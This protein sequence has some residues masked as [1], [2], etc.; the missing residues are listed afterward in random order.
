MKYL[1]TFENFENKEVNE[2]LFNYDQKNVKKDLEKGKKSIDEIFNRTF[3]EAFRMG[4]IKRTAE[5]LDEERKKEIL[6]KVIEDPD[7]IG[8]LRLK[9]EEIIYIP[10]NQVKLKGVGNAINGTSLS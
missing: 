10:K 6:E 1:K 4:I 5:K 2:G 9:G 3:Q 7:G 8:T